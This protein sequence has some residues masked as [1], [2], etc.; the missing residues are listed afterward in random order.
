MIKTNRFKINGLV[1]LMFSGLAIIFYFI[2]VILGTINYPGYDSLAQAVSDL[3]SDDSPSKMIARFFSTLYG[4]FSSLTAV[5]L[6]YVHRRTK[7]KSLKLGI[8]LLS[9]MYIIS[10]IGYGLFPL[11][12]NNF[13]NVMHIIVT[14]I[15]VL[16]TI[17]SLILLMIAFKKIDKIVYFYL[18]LL[19]FI[20]LMAGAISTN[21][22]PEAYFG[23]TER[24]SVF[25][26]VIYIGI[27]SFFNYEY[28][29]Q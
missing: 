15:V 8:Y 1:I 20:L 11:S 6:I 9:C 18:T 14:I 3:T 21:F 5:G 29:K 2:H 16:L 13:Q 23:L 10:A 27:I 22:V 7:V 12:D 19:S 28:I 25:T 17:A 24:F 26:V 4:L